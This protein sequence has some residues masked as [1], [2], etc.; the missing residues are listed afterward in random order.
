MDTINDMMVE[1]YQDLLSIFVAEHVF[2]S[3]LRCELLITWQKS[4]EKKK[5]SIVFSFLEV[6]LQECFYPYTFTLSNDLG[7]LS[8]HIIIYQKLIN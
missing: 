3:F 5:K 8:L 4:K 6:F 2:I 1:I 7:S